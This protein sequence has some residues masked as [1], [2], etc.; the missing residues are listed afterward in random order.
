MNKSDRTLEMAIRV[1]HKCRISKSTKIC[2]QIQ[3]R[4]VETRLVNSPLNLIKVMKVNLTAAQ[5]FR[6]S[7]K[8][9]KIQNLMG[10]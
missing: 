9:L 7:V 5:Q 8:R 4:N 6:R 1:R 2:R 10:H 3:K